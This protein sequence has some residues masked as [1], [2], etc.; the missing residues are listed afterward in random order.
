VRLTWRVVRVRWEA[1]GGTEGEMLAL[2]R[3]SL[4]KTVTMQRLCSSSLRIST[5]D[6]TF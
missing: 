6:G 2:H 1:A 3:V 4:P 5:C